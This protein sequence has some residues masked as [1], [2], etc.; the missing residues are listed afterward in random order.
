MLGAWPIAAKVP[1]HVLPDLNEAMLAP[2][3]YL[4]THERDV[5]WVE[6]QTWAYMT[7][8]HF[9]EWWRTTDSAV[10]RFSGLDTYAEVRWNDEVILRAD[11]AH[12]TWTSTP[13]AWTTA[14]GTLSITFDPVSERGQQRLEAFEAPL[15]A[16]NDPR[17]IG[18]QTS[19]FTRKAGYQFGWD[20]GPR[21]A[22]P[23]IPGTVTLCPWEPQP[24][25]LPWVE[26]LAASTE[27]AKVVIHDGEEWDVFWMRNGESVPVQRDGDTLTLSQPH[28][29]WP[30]N[31]GAQELYHLDWVHRRT[32]AV[33]SCSLG[34]RKLEWMEV[35]DHEGTTF[36]LHV[37]GV[38][39]HCRGA[40]VVPPD[41]HRAYDAAGWEE[42][43]ANAVAANMTMLR[44]W[45]GGVYPPDS[46]FDACDREGVL[47]WQ[48]FAFACAM[49]PDDPYFLDNLAREANEHVKRLRNRPSLALWCGNNEVERAWADWGWQNM[50][51]LHGADSARVMQAYLRVFHELLPSIV[52]RESDAYYLPSSPS[53]A[54]NA[55]DEH[56]WGV[57]FGLENFDYYS[58]NA[59]R[60]VSEY[61]LQSLPSMLA[62]QEAGISSFADEA[63]QFRQR[64]RMDWLEPGFDGWDMM[65]H[66]MDKTSGLPLTGDLQDWVV[67]SQATQAEGIRQ[68]LER[69][70]T[71][72]GR[73]AGSLYWSLNDVWPAVSWSTVDHAGVWK[74]AHYAAQRANAPRTALWRRASADALEFDAFNDFPEAFEGSLHVSVKAFDGTLVR[75]SSLPCSLPAHGSQSVEVGPLHTWQTDPK[76]TYLACELQ[77]SEGRIVSAQTSLWVPMVEADLPEEIIQVT[78]QGFELSMSADHYV[79]CVYLQASTRGWFTDNGMAIQPGDTV[80]V[81]FAPAKGTNDVNVKLEVFGL[82]GQAPVNESP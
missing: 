43:V 51:D 4:G 75:E 62:L 64:S 10:F 42:M 37:N 26:T 80:H 11:N 54:K 66:F 63:L 15:P 14:G 67:K 27:R 29:W 17:P 33:H 35:A 57:W 1:G 77:D 72:H 47:V 60:F 74:M 46:F 9:P 7:E 61:G 58:R 16:S 53:L 82:D 38:P 18:Q 22:G 39:V 59:G 13:V 41:F 68:A 71:S 78:R 23:G 20:W 44:V 34:L 69:H 32:G 73:Y 52:E 65:A 30:R 81:Q 70:R 2:N 21:L 31:Y 50:Y 5:Q 49:V 45:G 19:P 79:P 48:D 36:E 8:V 56:A 55:Q 28:L 3:P 6:H 76:N 12:R 24:L 25:R 40:N